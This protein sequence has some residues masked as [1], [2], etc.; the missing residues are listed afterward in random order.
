MP[1][2][3]HARRKFRLSCGCLREF[4]GMAAGKEHEVLCIPCHQ[5]VRT[6]YAY[7]ER[8]CG[9]EA[10]ITVGNR[11]LQVSCTNKTGN[12]QCG[13]G[14]HYDEYSKAGFSTSVRV[15]KGSWGNTGRV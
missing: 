4:P 5:P 7:P 1:K 13:T 3:H 10:R 15:G 6:L 11:M 8:A 14:V 9:Q 12:S 2:T